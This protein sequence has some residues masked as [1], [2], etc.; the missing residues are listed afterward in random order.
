[1]GVTG[2]TTTQVLV[3]S[4][5][6][7]LLEREREVAAIDDA[8][9]AARAG[10]GRLLYVEAHAGLGKSQLLAVGA[11]RAG[12]AGMAVLSAQGSELERGHSFGVAMQLFEA[13]LAKAGKGER[14]DLLGGAAAL[15]RP[16]FEH[17]TTAAASPEDQLF[18]LLHGLYWLTSNLAEERPLAI[19][20]DDAH[21]TDRA[22]LRFLLYLAQRLA[23][24][25]V[26]VLTSARP[27]EPGAPDD[28]L[29]QL[30]THPVVEVLHPNA[31]SR[32]GVEAL[33]RGRLA[34]AD[35]D[36]VDACARVTDGNPYLLTE[37]LA[38]LEDRGVEPTAASANEVGRLAPDSVLEA[39]LVRLARLPSGASRLARAVAVLGDEATVHRAAALAQLDRDVAAAAA[40]ALAAAELLR[41]GA[42]LSFVHPL[43]HSAIY[44]EIPEAERGEMHRRAARL[45]HDA[46]APVGTVAAH[47]L[48]ASPAGSAWAVDQL[49]RAAAQA[50]SQGATDSAGRYL[51]RALQEPPPGPAR[52]EVM[53]ELGR[54]ESLA[55]KAD[56]IDRLDQA[57]ELLD[58]PSRRAE[59]LR[60]LGWTHQ[61]RGN[62][63]QA[64]AA[65]E[66]G[67][68][69]LSGLDDDD[70]RT[71]LDVANLQ[72]AHLGAALL[73]S[74][75]AERAH[76]QVGALIK[77]GVA[78]LSL[79]ERGLLSVVAMHKLFRSEDH[80]AVI[81]LSKQAWGDGRLLE[82]EGSNFHTIWHVIGCLSWSD[83]LEDAERICEAALESARREGSIVTL[84]LGFYARSW[85]RYWRGDLA[86][87]AA[88][89]QAAMDAWS[90]E[91][92]M[93]LP[94]AAYWF[95]MAQLELGDIE[96]ASR[97]LDF[98][99]AEARWA[100]TNLYGP[101][102]AA[103]GRVAMERKNYSA[104]IDLFER[105]GTSVLGS[106]IANPA[107]IPWRT[108]LSSA[109]LAAGDRERAREVANEELD[110]CLRFGAP[111]PLGIALR[112]A[113]LAEGGKRGIELLGE[114]VATLRRSPSRLELARALIDLGAAVRRGGR[115]A[116]ARQPLREG[117]ELT[118]R[119]GAMVLERR[120]SEELLA[121][122]ARP[123]KRELTGAASLTPSELRVAEM[124]SSGMTNREIAQTLFVT[125][126][127]VQ[128]HLRNA[129][130][131]LDV[132]GREGLVDVLRKAD[133]NSRPRA[134]PP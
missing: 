58:D 104:A 26:A 23:E 114:S 30:R 73:E 113:G 16:V 79:N 94:V 43:L 117:L 122:G 64:V 45:V 119:F 89:A 88:D 31:L 17:H 46:G 29:R 130:R 72:I 11:K 98:P 108:Y 25:P 97:P 52:A 127:A 105:T 96:A 22:T 90:G 50:L 133:S 85:P 54:A 111:R 42:P 106:V 116:E 82:Q 67:L 60:E 57:L 4:R 129:Y 69:E 128:W 44:A 34:G 59:I 74:S 33:V 51:A 9:G 10:G 115:R 2:A 8:L 78:N 48:A 21:W 56:A 49:R 92:S 77:K 15:A 134:A 68:A 131:K 38:D 93:Y 5:A 47:L 107:V 39:A 71:R 126:K 84:A 101:L 37:L 125:V 61:K 35:A 109:H 70:V 53:L 102:L 86:G 32:V 76:R 100:D 12:E 118:Q 83:A 14:E 91:Y 112:S 110:L 63:K 66:R 1:M 27:A 103:R 28:L 55:G 81:S 3:G 40:D 18:S 65:F 123:R 132:H 95:A 87:A 6:I 19:V 13:R 36:F 120:A 80:E 62:I 99:D 20:A 41:A 75:H 24:L 7:A 124:A 121:T